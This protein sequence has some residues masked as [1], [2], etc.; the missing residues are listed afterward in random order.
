MTTVSKADSVSNPYGGSAVGP[1]PLVDPRVWPQIAQVPGGMKVAAAAPVADFLFRRAV[2]RLQVRVAMP[3]GEVIGAGSADAPLMTVYR[4]HDFAARVGDS[5]LIGFGEAYMAG[6]WD[7]EDLTAVLDVFAR[8]MASLIPKSL[9]R[10]RG[11]YI[12]KPPRSERNTTKNTRSNISRHYDLSNDLFELFLDETM[13]Y[14]S[15]LFA[16]SG[17]DDD[18]EELADAQRRKIDRLLDRAGVGEGTRVLEI[19]TGWGELAIRAAARGAT[20]RS[21]TLSTEQ[22]DLARKRCAAAGYGDRI[23]IDLL[24]YRLVDGEYD[25]IVSVEMIEAVGHQYW[26]T[27]FETIDALLAPGGR[28]ALQAITMPH[29]RMLATRNTYTWVHKYIFPG[30]FL[31]SVRAIEEVTEQSTS[32]RVRE[33][34]SMGDHYARTLAQW[35]RRF[36]EYRSE[37][38]ELGF[39]EVFARMWHFYLCYSEA[40]FRSG[41]LDVQQIVL[42]RRDN[43]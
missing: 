25:A 39:A 19:G 38:E 36:R 15:A 30:G 22:Q 31:P 34:L 3:D 16:E 33:R 29:D 12:P 24:D 9:Q 37:A 8:R 43:R 41:Y 27:Y 7:A 35:D 2:A 10:L 28:V 14:S 17:N 11:L 26:A 1:R 6:D 32:L 5:G 23:Q 42:D 40:G 21:V 13:T 18:S 20:V 4:P